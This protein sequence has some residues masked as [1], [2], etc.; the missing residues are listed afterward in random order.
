LT[1]AAE[2]VPHGVRIRIHD[3][4]TGIPVDVLPRIFEPW[5]TTKAAGLGTGLGLSITRDVVAAHG[6][7]ITVAAG[8]GAGTTFTIVLPA[9]PQPS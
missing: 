9:L 3:T 8:P 4:G 2:P 5:V 6:G 7:T 1:L